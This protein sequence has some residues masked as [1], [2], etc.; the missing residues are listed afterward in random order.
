MPSMA[1]ILGGGPAPPPGRPPGCLHTGQHRP[2]ALLA[3]GPVPSLQTKANTTLASLS[4][5]DGSVPRPTLQVWRCYLWPGPETT[6]GLGA[7]RGRLSRQLRAEASLLTAEGDGWGSQ[8][9]PRA[10]LELTESS[11][12]RGCCA[13]GNLHVSALSNEKVSGK[14]SWAEAAVMSRRS[15]PKLWASRGCVFTVRRRWEGKWPA[16]AGS[17]A[18]ETEDTGSANTLQGC[19]QAVPACSSRETLTPHTGPDPA[20]PPHFVQSGPRSQSQMGQRD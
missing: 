15:P 6:V 14:E 11:P 16:K 17:R 13:R 5:T 9:C 1:H 10:Q 18:A 3:A 4:K 8:G 2:L 12:Q 19:S 20:L 7:R